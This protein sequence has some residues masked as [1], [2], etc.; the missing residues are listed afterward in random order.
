LEVFGEHRPSLKKQNQAKAKNTPLSKPVSLYDYQA[1]KKKKVQ[2][3]EKK[4][5]GATKSYRASRRIS[6]RAAARE[7]LK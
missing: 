5:S 6:R 4:V 3:E 1:T 7:Q 2:I